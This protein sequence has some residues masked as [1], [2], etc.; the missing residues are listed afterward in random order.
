MVMASHL[1]WLRVP[2]ASS[3]L[4][5]P[6]VSTAKIEALEPG[7][8]GEARRQQKTPPQGEV[9]HGFRRQPQVGRRV[10]EKPPKSLPQ[11]GVRKPEALP[12][13]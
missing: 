9:R 13:N 4:A 6:R 3:S 12:L 8:Y 10:L 7:A 2:P 11:K 5:G 1:P